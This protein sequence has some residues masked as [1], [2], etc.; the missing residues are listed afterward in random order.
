MKFTATEPGSGN[1]WVE[2]G[3]ITFYLESIPDGW[4]LLQHKVDGWKHLITERHPLG[5]KFKTVDTFNSK[6]AAL[7]YLRANYD[8]L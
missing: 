1:F 4:R 6:A 2:A 5:R 3:G 7:E 8:Q